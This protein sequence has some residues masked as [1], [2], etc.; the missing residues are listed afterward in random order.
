MNM[1]T[2]I[3]LWAAVSL[4]AGLCT[5]AAE[6]APDT[7]YENY[8]V[9]YEKNVFSRTRY[10]PPA[11]GAGGPMRKEKVVLSL[12]VLRGIAVE[13]QKRVAFVEDEIGGQFKRMTIGEQLLNGTILEIRPDR[14]MFKQNDNLCEIRIGQEFDRV[15]SEVERPAGQ[16]PPPAEPN[17]PAAPVPA[18]AGSRPGSASDEEAVLKQ[19]MERRRQQVGN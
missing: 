11:D 18:A 3:L 12:Y 8:K 19:M 16:E 14:V 10:T 9:I 1:N 15:E 5:A 13:T 6:A 17:V 2:F 4:T 7:S